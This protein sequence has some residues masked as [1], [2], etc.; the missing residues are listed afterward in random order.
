MNSSI[1]SRVFCIGGLP[2]YKLSNTL[3]VCDYGK[4]FALI[5]I[6][7]FCSNRICVKL[8]CQ[9]LVAFSFIMY[10]FLCLSND[11]KR[12]LVFEVKNRCTSNC[13]HLIDTSDYKIIWFKEAMLCYYINLSLESIWVKLHLSDSCN[14]CSQC[15]M[16]LIK[17]LKQ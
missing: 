13:W 1:L 6:N 7:C 12:C 17:S 8:N 16:V 3:K 10:C 2:I 9:Y 4:F 14:I 11:L 5:I 15:Y